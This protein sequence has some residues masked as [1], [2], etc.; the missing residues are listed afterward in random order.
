[1]STPIS[2]NLS[3]EETPIILLHGWGM[4]RQIWGELYTLL[5]DEIQQR[6]RCLDLPGYGD[7]RVELAEY[8]LCSLTDWL[9]A[10]I[11]E[12]SVVIGWSLGGLIA[13]NLAFHY[14]DKVSKIGLVSTSPRFMQDETWP[15]IKPD[16]LTLF[17]SQLSQDHVKTVERFLAIQAMGSDSARQD[18]TALKN[19]VLSVLPPEQTALKKGLNILQ[20]VDLREQLKQLACPVFALFGKLDSLVPI[21]VE[22]EVLML[23][24]NIQTT[25]FEKCSHAPFI[26]DKIKFKTWLLDV[27][28]A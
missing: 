6:I 13:Q 5:P 4:N 27:I 12:P 28:A 24:P 14:P 9:A 15:G 7:N 18:I 20:Q 3:T 11:N 25:R 26:S 1:M 21:S 19:V 17:L 16:V 2:Y 22:H 8:D 23:N 10:Q